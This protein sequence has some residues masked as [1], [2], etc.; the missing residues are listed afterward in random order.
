[1]LHEVDRADRAPL[2][3]PLKELPNVF[4]ATGHGGYGIEV[5]PYSGALVAELIAG[6]T[7]AIDLSPF[8]PGRSS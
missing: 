1:M 8:A 4:V 6:R 2:L 3:G 7:P 5:G